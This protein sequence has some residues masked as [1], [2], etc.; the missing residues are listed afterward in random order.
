[1]TLDKL[2]FPIGEFEK[3][4][5]IT[6]NILT[7]WISVIALFPEKLTSEVNNLTDSQLDTPYRPGGWTV[8]QV[9][10]HCADSHI[11]SLTRFKL[12]LTED[13][14]TIKPYFEDRWAEL[15]DS[16]TLPIDSSLKILEG[17]HARW[18]TLLNNLTNQQLKRTFVHPEKGKALS[19]D[20]ATGLYAWH[21]NHH[22]AHITT[23][24]QRK[25]W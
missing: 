10:H 19:L 12:A 7:N 23:L 8:R 20:E 2:K 11:N 1:M 14:P 13:N 18:I 6:E 15:P 16:K 17:I 25:N 5:T 22:L 3:P 9:V 24:K 21:C 4:E